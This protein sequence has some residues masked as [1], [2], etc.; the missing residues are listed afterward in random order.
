MLKP[1]WSR[2]EFLW[3]S[4]TAGT[5][6]ALKY[7]WNSVM[8]PAVVGANDR[9]RVGIIGLGGKG[10]RHLA[11]YLKLPNVQV[12]AVCD[13]DESKLRLV[14]G[15]MSRAGLMQPFM[16]TNYSRL[17]ELSDIDLLSVATP[18]VQRVQIGMDACEAG[19]H[20][21]ME[22]PFAPSVTEG[23]KLVKRAQETGRFVQ[24][25]ESF[26]F[27]SRSE[28]S[29]LAQ[30]IAVGDIHAVRGWKRVTI[31]SAVANIRTA[32][33]SADSKY[34]DLIDFALD[35][36]DMARCLLD[37][38]SP[39]GVTSVSFGDYANQTLPAR[40]AMQFDFCQAGRRRKLLS[41]E[42]EAAKPGN[43]SPGNERFES[44][45]VYSTSRGEFSLE[46]SS[47]FEKS[48]AGSNSWENL[49]ASIRAENMAGL[50]NPISEAQ[51]SCELVHLA[52]ESLRV[53]HL[54]S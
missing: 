40:V 5:G 43:S 1:G 18:R 4:L 17:L 16:T 41:L 12:A 39:D 34:D 27:A 50:Q 44:K 20:L 3:L 54:R 13:P 31:P 29:S 33:V 52:A 42:L 2:R 22:K 24:Q 46:Y 30:P 32:R 38:E 6:V 26:V 15:E 8:P 23:R 11:E 9:I 45:S 25:R 36:L 35:E 48:D 21:L 51:K 19:K 47:D 53:V 28:I 49:V 37:V 10:R 7:H 14:S